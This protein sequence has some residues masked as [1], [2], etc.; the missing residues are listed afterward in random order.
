MTLTVTDN[1]G[2]T[3]TVTRDVTVTAP[4]PANQPPTADFTTA[5]GLTASITSIS[6]DPD[7]TVAAYAWNFG[8]NST[9]IVSTPT[10]S[11]TFATGTYQVTLTVTDNSGATATVTKPVTVTSPAPTSLAADAFGRTISNAWG[12]ADNGGAWTVSGGAA[13][14]GLGR[15]RKG[16]IDRSGSR[17]IGHPGGPVERRTST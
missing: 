9:D 2:A 3:A 8:D 14:F 16:Q 4:P 7:G 17:P 1:N 13:N 6:T 11:H 15:Q 10:A 5:V 12:T